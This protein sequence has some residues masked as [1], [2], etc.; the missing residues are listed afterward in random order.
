MNA[1]ESWTSNLFFECC[2]CF[3]CNDAL[4]AAGF[5]DGALKEIVSSAGGSR[6]SCISTHQQFLAGIVVSAQ[7]NAQL[8]FWNFQIFTQITV[9]AHQ[10]QEAV[11]YISQ[12]VIFTLNVWNVHVVGGWTDILVFLAGEYVD[13]DHVDLS[14]TVLA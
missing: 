12:L 11:V 3:D 13:A 8:A 4:F 14:V 1:W 9:V 6:I 10:D 7:L 5:Q 2:V